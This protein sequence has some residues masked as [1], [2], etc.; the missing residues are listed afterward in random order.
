[1]WAEPEVGQQ[2]TR[3]QGADMRSRVILSLVAI[4]IVCNFGCSPNIKNLSI[5]EKN[6][7]TFLDQVRSSSGLTGEEF[8][9]LAGYIARRELSIA[10]RGEELPLVG[11]TVGDLI[12]LQ[13]EWV[14]NLKAQEA[15]A[16]QLAETARQKEEAVAA[17]LREAI[18]LSVY[19]K[20]FV[21][22]NY[23]LNLYSD[24]ITIK[25]SYQNKSAQDIRAFQ[26]VVTFKDLF[27]DVIY[28]TSLKISDPIRSLK[29]ATWSGQIE[30]NQFDDKLTRFRSA[31]LKDMKI[32]WHPIK[33]ILTDGTELGVDTSDK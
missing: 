10:L 13:R 31:E 25:V 14:D 28:Q 29:S 21:E 17:Q 24:Y 22:A 33:V 11:K 3:N 1:M 6:K 12:N 7:A 4:V 18:A 8:E 26:G 20:G 16:K 19:D 23:R 30:Y 15:E 27:G 9:L 32:E 5:T 2:M